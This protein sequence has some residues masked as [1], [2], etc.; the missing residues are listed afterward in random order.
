MYLFRHKLVLHM[1]LNYYYFDEKLNDLNDIFPSTTL[2]LT[3]CGC[4]QNITG[5]F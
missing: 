4:K 5:L 2:H 3:N 1:T